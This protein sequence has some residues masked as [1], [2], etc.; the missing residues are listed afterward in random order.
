MHLISAQW[1]RYFLFENGSFSVR[2]IR[3]LTYS[4]CH[5]MKIFS[6]QS[7]FSRMFRA[8]SLSLC[9]TR[10]LPN[11]SI[12]W[13]IVRVVNVKS[14]WTLL[15]TGLRLRGTG[16][17]DRNVT[18]SISKLDLP[19]PQVFCTA[20]VRRFGL[21]TLLASIK[22]SHGLDCFFFTVLSAKDSCMIYFLL[23]RFSKSRCYLNDA[24]RDDIQNFIRSISNLKL[25]K[26]YDNYSITKGW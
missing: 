5:F 2:C 13:K 10:T 4:A 7:I 12:K 9:S 11:P 18:K 8:V 6:Y 19:L 15:C 17:I 25:V 16:I 24:M 14:W 23:N 21:T 22:I 20:Y 26:D 1:V 3:S